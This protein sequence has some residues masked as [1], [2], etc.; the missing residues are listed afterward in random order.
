[1]W[2]LLEMYTESKYFKVFTKDSHDLITLLIAHMYSS[3]FSKEKM[4]RMWKHC[5][6]ATCINSNR[7]NGIAWKLLCHL[8]V[9][10]Q[11]NVKIMNL[12]LAKVVGFF[13]QV[14]QRLKIEHNQVLLDARG[15][16]W[17]WCKLEV[18]KVHILTR[19]TPSVCFLFSWVKIFFERFE[20]SGICQRQK[21]G[22]QLLSVGRNLLIMWFLFSLNEAE[23][24]VLIYSTCRSRHLGYN[25]RA[26][27]LSPP[28]CPGR[29]SGAGPQRRGGP[30]TNWAPTWKQETVYQ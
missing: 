19:H 9:T 29:S 13:L 16:W 14:Q 7:T 3:G 15:F 27:S 26:G 22:S 2:L 8:K 11:I 17:Q 6:M 28:P 20:G 5:F 24:T 30:H 4:N 23:I 10:A 25:H 12:F 21:S 18:M 1:M